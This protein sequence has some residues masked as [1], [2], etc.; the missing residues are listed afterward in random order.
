MTIICVNSIK[1]KNKIRSVGTILLVASIVWPFI[2]IPIGIGLISKAME[3]DSDSG[4]YIGL[5]F[6]LSGIVP[7]AV[8]LISIGDMKTDSDEISRANWG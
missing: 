7:L 4:Y 1:L 2:G 3:L 6:L 8:V 5:I